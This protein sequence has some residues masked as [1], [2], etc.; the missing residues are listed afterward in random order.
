MFRNYLNFDTPPWLAGISNAKTLPIRETIW[1]RPWKCQNKFKIG[2][3]G[4]SLI[5]FLNFKFSADYK[6]KLL[7]KRDV[8]LDLD[9]LKITINKKAKYVTEMQ[10]QDITGLAGSFR[11]LEVDW[12]FARFNLREECKCRFYLWCGRA[13]S[14][15]LWVQRTTELPGA[16]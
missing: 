10:D 16:S 11:K 5:I 3:S 6:E 2:R 14:Q 8:L 9:N 15:V 4:L 12:R 1:G 13:S 7:K